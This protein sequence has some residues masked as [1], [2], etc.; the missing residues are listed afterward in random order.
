MKLITKSE[1]RS[2]VKLF[3]MLLLGSLLLLSFEIKAQTTAIKTK[4]LNLAAGEYNLQFEKMFCN[5]VSLQIGGS[6]IGREMA[7]TSGNN[8]YQSFTT[9]YTISPELRVYLTRRGKGGVRGMYIAPFLDYRQVRQNLDDMPVGYEPD[10]SFVEDRKTMSGGIMVGRQFVWLRHLTLDVAVGAQFR[11]RAVNRIYDIPGVTDFD[12]QQ[13]FTD[14]QINDMA[15]VR[16]KGN[17]GVGL[18]F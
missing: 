9:G 5:V 16:L 17:L 12:F 7:Q 18:A 10:V 15:G 14:F 1:K 3:F 13:K 11:E 2:F 4:P 6:L 8:F